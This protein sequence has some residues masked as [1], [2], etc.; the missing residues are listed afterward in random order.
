MAGNE[1]KARL[2]VESLENR[3]V[4]AFS[5]VQLAGSTLVIQGAPNPELIQVFARGNRVFVELI[6]LS[7]PGGA[8]VIEQFRRDRVRHVEVHE[9]EANEDLFD[10]EMHDRHVETQ[11]FSGQ[12]LLMSDDHGDHGQGNDDGSEHH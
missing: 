1:R 3:L 2:E 9:D 4:P 6:D 5:A 12:G 10:N 11:V 8:V 7:E